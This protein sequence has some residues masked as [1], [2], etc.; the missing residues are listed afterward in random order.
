MTKTERKALLEQFAVAQAMYDHLGRLVKAS[1]SSGVPGDLRAEANA[2]AIDAYE[3][4]HSDRTVISLNGLDVGAVRVN[5]RQG[6]AVTDVDAYTVWCQEHKKMVDTTRIDL[7]VLSSSEYEE[8][9]NFIFDEL[10]RTDAIVDTHDPVRPEDLGLVCDPGAKVAVDPDTGEVV[11][12][13]EF[14]TIVVNTSVEGFKLDGAKS[15]AAAKYTPV[16][17]AFMSLPANRRIDMLMG[18]ADG[19]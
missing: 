12:G 4:H 10:G 18:G 17:V 14:R 15:G 1:T 2:A 6:W 19:D 16:R 9:A 11:P 5:T 8:V 13:L 3:E 7:G